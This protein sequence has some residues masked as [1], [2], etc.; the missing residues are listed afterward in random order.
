MLK[1][2]VIAIG[3]VFSVVL[4]VFIVEVALQ[5]RRETA[6]TNAK[7]AST[8]TITHGDKTWTTKKEPY[9]Y[10]HYIKFTTVDHKIVYIFDGVVELTKTP[11]SATNSHDK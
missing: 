6:E 3:F 11:K 8:Y 2:T 5:F 1:T 7:Y 4:I 9:V 10:T